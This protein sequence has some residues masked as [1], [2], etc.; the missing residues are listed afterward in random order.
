[1]TLVNILIGI[2]MILI[3]MMLITLRVRIDK[4]ETKVDELGGQRH[5]ADK[6]Y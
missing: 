1:M 6:N 4:I 5:D 2:E 3:V